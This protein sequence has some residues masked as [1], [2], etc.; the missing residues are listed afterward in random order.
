L[1]AEPAPPTTVSEPSEAANVHIADSL[2]GLAIPELARATAIADIGAGA[3]FPGLALATAL[4]DANFDL[5]E[6]I[7]RL[8]AAAGLGNAQP[9][10][11]RAEEWAAGDGGERYEVVTARALAS[12][13]VLAEYAAPLL[14]HAGILVAWK[15]A[16]D[17]AEEAAGAAAAALVGLEP[18]EPLAVRPFKGSRERNLFVYEKVA[19]TPER[20]PRRPGMA[21][22]RPL[23]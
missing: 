15:G 22:K 20:F 14:A 17:P 6:V 9:V 21:T 23:A 5:I 16:R 13:A 1:S 19:P 18:R 12:L 4:P 10:P 3:G 2:S 7:A 11:A 8:A